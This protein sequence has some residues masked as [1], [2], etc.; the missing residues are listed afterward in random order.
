M[1]SVWSEA[2]FFFW[3]NW[4][5]LFA[6]WP[7]L[8]GRLVMG[9]YMRAWALIV[10]SRLHHSPPATSSIIEIPKCGIIAM[11]TNEMIGLSSGKWV[12]QTRK[13]HMFLHAVKYRTHPLPTLYTTSTIHRWRVLQA[14][15]PISDLVSNWWFFPG[16]WFFIISLRRLLKLQRIYFIFYFYFA[17]VFVVFVVSTVPSLPPQNVSSHNTSSTSLHVSWQEVPHGF[18]HGILLGYRILFKIAN[19]TED[20]SI[21]STSATTRYKDL[22]GLGKFTV[23]KISVL[24]FTAIGDGPNSTIVFISTDEDS[25]C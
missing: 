7:I 25:K 16:P 15:A 22:H 17:V 18:V 24:A 12:G 5:V 8:S 14:I 19:K 1:W 20:F 3:Q 13:Y 9:R 2:I 4:R 6:D 23:Y 11:V 10:N 21:V